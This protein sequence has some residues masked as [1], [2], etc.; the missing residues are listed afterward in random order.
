MSAVTIQRLEAIELFRGC[1]RS[2]LA[3]VDCLGSTLALRAGR[4]LC[5]EG[6]PGCEFFLLVDGL[7][8]VERSGRAV[9]RLRPGAWFGETALVNHSCRQA[10]VTT[11]ED[12]MLIVFG[13]R[14]FNALR[15]VTPEVDQRLRD[16]A[17]LFA[18][19]GT[20]T[21][22]LWYQ[23]IDELVPA[24]DRAVGA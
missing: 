2:Q 18:H 14:E 16:T 3:Y 6:E 20:P 12:S 24:N 9:A 11:V 1:R 8:E 15:R 4:E 19:G 22:W 10:G 5:R 7:V 13:P 23:P 17:A 21:S